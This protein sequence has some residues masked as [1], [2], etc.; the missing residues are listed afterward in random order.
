MN[1]AALAHRRLGHEAERIRLLRRALELD[2]E[3]ATAWSSLGNAYAA[4]GERDRARACY[5]QARRLRPGWEVP[6]RN[7]S[8]LEAGRGR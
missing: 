7:L 5:R 2:P 3:Y 4:A 6:A 8:L 1:A